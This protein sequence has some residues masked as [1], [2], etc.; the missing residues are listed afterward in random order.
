MALELARIGVVLEYST[1]CDVWVLLEYLYSTLSQVVRIPR[2]AFNCPTRVTHACLPLHPYSRNNNNFYDLSNILL[3]GPHRFFR[4]ASSLGER[5]GT[6]HLKATSSDLVRHPTSSKT[7]PLHPYMYHPCSD[8]LDTLQ[9]LTGAITVSLGSNK[10]PNRGHTG[11]VLLNHTPP[12]EMNL[13][14]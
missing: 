4:R 9:Y 11:S 8:A 3:E 14:G 1:L 6:L 7:Q 13:H 5:G 10:G 2:K 12:K